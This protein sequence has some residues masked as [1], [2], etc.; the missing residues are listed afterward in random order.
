MSDLILV[1][2]NI[3]LGVGEKTISGFIAIKD[4]LIEHV[5]T[6][7]ELPNYSG[8]KIDLGSKLIMPGLH[9]AHLH[10]FMSGLYAQPSVLVSDSDTSEEECVLKLREIENLVPHDEWMIGTGW[11]HPNWD[12][13]DLPTKKSLDAIYPDRP[14]VMVA[15][16]CHTL[17]INSCGM[18]K[19]G[20]DKNTQDIPG[21]FIM[22]D[23]NGEPTGTFHEA[24]A[25][26]L[27]RKIYDF[28]EEKIL[29]FYKDFI[30]ILNSYGITSVCDM[31]IM[32]VPGL[33]FIRD[34]IFEQLEKNGELTVRVHMYPTMTH[35]LERPLAMREKYQG[36]MLFCNGVK[37]FFDGV[38]GC[39]TAFLKEPYANAYFPGDVGKTTVPPEEMR[40]LFFEAYEN[41]FSFR[42]HTIGDQAIHLMIDYALEAKKK[43]GE[44]PHLHH[45]LEHLENFQEEDITRL[46]TS[47]LTASVQ[48]AHV[49]FT[50]A[51]V[52]RDLGPKRTPLM[53]P[54]RSLLDA[55][56]HLAFGTDSPVVDV[57]PFYG[58][59]NAVTRQSA[60]SGTPVGGWHPEQKITPAEAI[61]AYTAGAAYAANADKLY[62][63][64]ETGKFADI[65]V[66]D[67]N[68]ICPDTPE[69][70][71]S[72]KCVMTL[73]G[74]KIVWEN[75]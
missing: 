27:F 35:G 23:K 8:K 34:D 55:N 33:D 15:G 25:T 32:A 42:V 57:N 62:G 70:I 40:S 20:I 74:G 38:S 21:G 17:W 54:F 65:A 50:V 45:T 18:N 61:R 68:I 4:G 13:P 19:L 46:A 24:W 16:D 41:D 60:S 75:K 39:H 1:S 58:I 9:D 67:K 30:H 44:K 26:S 59:Y 2:E 10:F 6:M 12:K 22:R 43:F 64:L 7:S 28:S 66:M 72:S 5:G 14:V 63:T 29:G 53:W 52:E 71:L 3:Y 51:G 47:G 73:V 69:D 11:N 48:P 56:N 31:S 49:L 36:P 37:H